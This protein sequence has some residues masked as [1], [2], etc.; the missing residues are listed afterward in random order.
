MS[1]TPKR[2]LRA[3]LVPSWL[4]RVLPTVRAVLHTRAVV[5]R[6]V[7]V[8]K[9][10]V[11]PT[12]AVLVGAVG[13][14]ATA[15]ADEYVALGDSYSSGTGTA[16]YVDQ[17]CRRSDAAFP[18]L[19]ASARPGTALTSVACSGA[20]I[21][22]VE[23]NQLD[24][25]SPATALVTLTVGGNDAG[26]TGVI[27]RCALPGWVTRCSRPVTRARGFLRRELPARLDR[28]YAAIRLRAPAATVVV[29]GYPRLLNGIDCGPVTFFSRAESRLL[30]GTADLLRD[31][32]RARARAAG[33]RFADV[34]PAFDGHAVCDD[35]EWLNGLS[36]PLRESFHP[37]AV[38]HAE[39]YLPAIL[40]QL[41]GGAS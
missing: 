29:A 9:R 19:L 35:P 34:I 7:V 18:A 30:N 4:H 28:L 5:A 11:L 15:S 40:A 32:L 17:A 14:T 26:F 21:P 12:A 1:P 41:D 23:R 31:V 8:A 27:A 37:N 16:A 3:G 25:L 24:A 6:R 22:D 20:T 36:A 39:G 13:S 33:F 38:G 10:A 2:V